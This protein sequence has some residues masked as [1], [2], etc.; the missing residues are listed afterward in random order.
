MQTG[1]E[2]IKTEATAAPATPASDIETRDNTDK[3]LKPQNPDLYYG[4]L[5]IECYYFYQQ[6]KDFFQ[7]VGWLGHKC[8]RFTAR[9]RKDRIF[10]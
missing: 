1:I 5:H 3:P 4:N 9:F 2:M 8:I 6:C 10:N 7:V